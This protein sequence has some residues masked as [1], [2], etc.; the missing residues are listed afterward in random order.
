MDYPT[1]HDAEACVLGAI[2]TKGE[3]FREVSGTLRENH[4]WDERHRVIWRAIVALDADGRV[5]DEITVVG[6]LRSVKNL[7]RAGGATYITSLTGTLP[8]VANVTSYSQEVKD[9]YDSRE[10][11]RIGKNLQNNVI[12]PPDRLDIALAALT[13]LNR[14]SVR[15]REKPIGNVCSSVLNGVLDSNGTEEKIY[16]GF[17]TLDEALQIQKDYYVVLG[18]WPGVGKSAFSLQ[19]AMNVARTGRRVL[20]ISPEM[21]CDQLGTRQL[22]VESGV[23][24][25]KLLR[26]KSLTEEER[27]KLREAAESVRALNLFINDR[28][29]QNVG[30]VR[31]AARR[32]YANQGLSLIVVD[33]LQ[34]L[35]A[36]DDTKEAVTTVSKGL[37]SIARD[38]NVPLWA[39]SQLRRPGYDERG[40]RPDKAMLRGSGQIEQDADQIM[41]MWNPDRKTRRKLRFL[42]TRT[43]TAL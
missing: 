39:C 25:S 4:F 42:S 10:L 16:T 20:Y 41:L 15:Q 29:E 32:I 36:G 11:M 30:S 24:H 38:L 17:R 3:C 40:R 9:A 31:L 28:S 13:D 18:A 33:Y 21:S 2:L 26:P 1:A 34:L 12:E 43:A 35:C 37:K 23:D 14:S 5:P 19:V 6:K 8:D 7:T 22:S 27:L